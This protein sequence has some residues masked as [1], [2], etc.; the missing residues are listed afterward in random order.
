ME[1]I[2]KVELD[3]S[4]YAGKDLYSDGA[5]ED[6][7]LEIAKAYGESDYNRIIAETASWPVMY[8]FSNIRQNIVEWAP[9]T[10]ED[11]VLEIGSGCGAITGALARKAKEVNCIE[12][13]KREAKSMRI[14]TV[15]VRM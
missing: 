5:V 11:S 10:K 14:E 8:H 9:I 7:L 12:L 2:G 1:K 13:S 3:E 15:I 4:C 6:R